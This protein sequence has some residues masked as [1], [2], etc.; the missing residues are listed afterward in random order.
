M[1]EGFLTTQ[2]NATAL[3]SRHDGGGSGAGPGGTAGNE[4]GRGE[5]APEAA[6][7]RMTLAHRPGTG[8]GA[9]AS[10][11]NTARDELA[12]TAHGH[13]GGLGAADW[14]ECLYAFHASRGDWRKA[15]HAMHTLTQRRKEEPRWDASAEALLAAELMTLNALSLV[16]EQHR[17]LTPRSLGGGGGKRDRT[18]RASPALTAQ[19]DI[20]TMRTLRRDSAL[21]AAQVAAGKLAGGRSTAPH[22]D[23]AE[24]RRGERSGAGR[25]RAS[26][27]SPPQP[28]AK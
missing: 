8:T 28:R 2:A 22:I 16:D 4:G 17:F 9:G 7:G 3:S 6:S 20:V 14:H 12:D 24:V 25:G 5:E 1:I 13:A 21:A 26:E 23:K 19:L 10:T 27:A 15:A 11:A 18:G